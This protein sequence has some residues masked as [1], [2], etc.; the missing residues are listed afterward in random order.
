MRPRSVPF[1]AFCL[2]ESQTPNEYS[3]LKLKQ[4]QNNFA[5]WQT[6]IVYAVEFAH[7]PGRDLI[8]MS[9]KRTN[10]IPIIEDARCVWVAGGAGGGRW[11]AGSGWQ[12]VGN[13]EE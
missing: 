7:R 3:E 1:T 2:S 8:N 5:L 10:I 11:V 4:V 12:A 13:D 6:G 9:K